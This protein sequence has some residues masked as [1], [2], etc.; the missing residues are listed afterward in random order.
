MTSNATSFPPNSVAATVLAP[1][2]GIS[3]SLDAL[4]QTLQASNTFA[5]LPAIAAE[6]TTADDDLTRA[7]EL[8]KQHQA[9][10]ARILHLRQQAGDLENNIK[11]T[12]RR[13]RQLRAEITSIHPSIDDDEALSDNE[14]D[15]PPTVDYE[16]LL[17]FASRIGKH[18]SLAK[19]E[20]EQEGTRLKLKAQEA[21][22][23]SE[24]LQASRQQI[25]GTSTSADNTA[26]QAQPDA[27]GEQF[28][29]IARQAADLSNEVQRFEASSRLP[30]PDA[31]LLRR[32]A[33]GRLDLVREA[34]DGDPD[35][36][37]EREV[38]RMVRETED[39]AAVIAAAPI[40]RTVE[41]PKQ[42]REPQTSVSGPSQA[43]TSRPVAPQAPPKPKT[44]VNLDFPGADS[45]DEDDD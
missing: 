39:V 45:D 43:S 4:V 19:Q 11:D 21:R 10:Y 20:A 18:N 42:E 29:L 41:R 22:R 23:K 8:L 9:N 40:A 13:A 3:S 1:L 25:N 37:V 36:A 34:D 30:F 17:Q 38:E 15:E 27:A 14:D 7:L 31:A 24:A 28:D 32:G 16:Q 2:D 26:E 5:Q 6:I 12:I 44:K 35:G 33:L